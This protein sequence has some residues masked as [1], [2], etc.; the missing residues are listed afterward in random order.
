MIKVITPAQEAK[1]AIYEIDGPTFFVIYGES[2]LITKDLM[3]IIAK[4][5]LEVIQK[6]SIY[7][8]H[9]DACIKYGKEVSQSEWFEISQ[10]F[11]Q[12]YTKQINN[13][14][15]IENAHEIFCL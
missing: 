14:L 12:N 4:D 5:K 7:N 13:L 6:G 10:A 3:V 2:H 9:F 11:G 15:S 1:P 8:I